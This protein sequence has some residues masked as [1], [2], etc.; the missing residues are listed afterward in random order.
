V[1]TAATAHRAAASSS[2][3]AAETRP[4][5]R[6]RTRS[7]FWRKERPA[8]RSN[9]V[10]PLVKGGCRI[11][12]P[13][14]S[15]IRMGHGRVRPGGRPRRARRKASRAGD[16]PSRHRRVRVAGPLRDRVTRYGGRRFCTARARRVRGRSTVVER[17]RTGHSRPARPLK[18]PRAG[19]AR[20]FTSRT[21]SRL[22]AAVGDGLCRRG[23]ADREELR[24]VKRSSAV[25]DR[26]FR[27]AK[28]RR[29]PFPSNIFSP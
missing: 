20:L 27:F 26:G 15:T 21:A 12:V 5:R 1:R 22:R 4:R 3:R 18:S 29:W 13:G 2:A 14:P 7:A 6:C 10:V 16:H 9:R 23:A 24:D 11:R 19:T 28:P 25:L 8:F 17:P